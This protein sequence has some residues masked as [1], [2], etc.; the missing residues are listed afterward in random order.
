MSARKAAVSQVLTA[1]HEQETEQLE[2]Y[3][4]LKLNLTEGP[5]GKLQP[6][7]S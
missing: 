5:A 1:A 4:D 6:Q 7:C 3:L 2:R